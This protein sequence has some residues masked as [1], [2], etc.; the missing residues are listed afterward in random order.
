MIGLLWYLGESATALAVFYAV[1]RLVLRDDTHFQAGRLY[2][3]S[4][5][6][7]ACLVPL[8]HLTSPFRQVVVPAGLLEGLDGPARSADGWTWP[9]VLVSIYA[10]GAALVLSRLAVSLVRLLLI[11]RRH[12][13]VDRD[14][15]RVVYVDE[16][17]PPFSFLRTAFVHCPPTGDDVVLE[18]VVAHEC[19]HIRQ[20]HS[21]DILLVH[22][23]A[24]MQWFNPFI[25]LYR[26]AL[27]ELH[28]YLADREVL[29]QG[30]DPFTYRQILFEQHLGARSFELAHH[31]RE[32]KIKRRLAMMTRRSGSWTVLRYLLAV[33]ALALLLVAFADP[34]VTVA[35]SAKAA[36]AHAAAKTDPSK[37]NAAKDTE[38]A[39]IDAEYK[40]K[41]DAL[42]ADYAAA[43][44]PDT[45]KA[46]EEKMLKVKQYYTQRVQQVDLSDP[47]TVEELIAKVS[48]K[49]EEID[50]KRAEVT[51]AE[52][53]HKLQQERE[54]L[55][56]K[57]Q[58]LKARLVQLRATK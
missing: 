7:A 10:A 2:L 52:T 28:E 22:L 38:K 8:V 34:Q 44:D 41:M 13:A 39:K 37:A 51:D 1:Y 33:P 24:A 56:K 58:D 9:L 17:C 29:A 12:P 16:D 6:A 40:S 11:A 32:S 54:M 4:T 42:K 48:K 27:K 25:W 30:F 5:L 53:Q 49:I 55:A 20:G 26:H 18:Q 14:G 47:A 19:T 31:L 21:L 3:L 36:E 57:Q 50:A 23:V 35:Q 46:I 43:T 15:V 45:K